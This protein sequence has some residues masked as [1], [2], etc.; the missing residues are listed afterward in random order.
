MFVFCPQCGLIQ[1]KN[2]VSVCPACECGLQ[3]VPK[4]YLTE[5]GNLFKSQ[6]ARRIFTENVIKASESYNAEL[7][8]RREDI[9]A[10]KEKLHKISVNEKVKKYNET[11]A[12][13]KCP[14]CSS[15]NLS[16]IS[17]AGKIAKVTVFGVLGA[18]DLGKK[19]RCNSCGY[20]F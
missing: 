6:D 8:D 9:L 3:D 16:K 13:F 10:E 20:K 18:G 19:W 12:V 4:E 7:A 1:K 17:N 5:Q 15:G 14:V 11:K 2:K